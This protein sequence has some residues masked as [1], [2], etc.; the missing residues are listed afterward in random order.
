MPELRCRIYSAERK[1]RDQAIGVK[2]VSNKKTCD[3]RIVS[4]HITD[5]R[6]SPQRGPYSLP[7]PHAR[8]LPVGNEQEHRN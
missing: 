5:C 6:Q 3:T 1:Q 4:Q 7:K 8:G 2:H